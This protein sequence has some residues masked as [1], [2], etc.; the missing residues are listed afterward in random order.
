MKKFEF[1]L[2]KMLSFKDQM[3]S[4][5]KLKLADLRS[6]L[7]HLN[8]VLEQ[9]R[10]EFAYCDAELKEQERT[11]L[12][13]QGFSRRKAYLNALSEKIKL[14]QQHIRTMEAKVSDQVAVVVRVSQEVTTLEKLKDRQ[15][16]EYRTAEGK[17]Q[18]LLIDEFVANNSVSQN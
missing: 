12:T 2:E 6:R 5:E 1:S 8:E 14:Q 17:E 16:E 15:L 7:A 9:L 4:G 10:K 11:G 13:P 18:E 3:L